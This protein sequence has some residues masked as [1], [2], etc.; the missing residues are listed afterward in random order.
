MKLRLLITTAVAVSMVLA[1][2]GAKTPVPVGL[3]P[4]QRAAYLQD[5]PADAQRLF[6]RVVDDGE[7]S[8]VLN[9]A[10]AALAAFQLGDS[11]SAAAALD[12]ARTPIEAVFSDTPDAKKA[13]SIWSKESSKRFLGE[14]YERA[15]VYYYR[16]LIF[17]EAGD[18]ENA[19]AS[20]RGGQLQDALTEDVANSQDFASLAY[21]RGWA[22]KCGG[23]ATVA[24]E[25]FAEAQKLKPEL[26]APLATENT[27]LIVESGGAPVKVGEGKYKE[28]LTFQQNDAPFASSFSLNGQAV[29]AVEAEDLFWQATSRGHRQMDT[30]LSN[31]AKTK[32]GTA[33]VGSAAISVGAAMMQQS[34]LS[35]NNDMAG[36][37]GMAMLG[38]LFASAMA[39]KMTPAADTR[40]WDNLPYKIYL[41]PVAVSGAD[42]PR[43]AF[44]GAD[45]ASTPAFVRT[46]GTP[47]CQVIWARTKSAL[48][49][50]DMAPGVTPPKGKK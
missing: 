33:A 16:G 6:A 30:L 47:A 9:D 32:E 2:A 21:L 3:S 20:F 49:V 14:G 40:Q 4:E 38:G 23:M 37:G 7:N 10:R 27:L 48:D 17:L 34:Y 44:T 8:A 11:K 35:N 13:R 50:P 29:P 22:G 39:A 12:D 31:K 45:G 43:V 26:K 19:A 42:A 15:M 41:H 36:L 18:Y 28:T 5:K 46:L 24:E 25:S 1:Q